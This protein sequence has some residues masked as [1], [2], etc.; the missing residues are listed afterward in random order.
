MTGIPGLE[1]GGS[2]E[3]SISRCFSTSNNSSRSGS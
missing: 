2:K 1:L 3:R